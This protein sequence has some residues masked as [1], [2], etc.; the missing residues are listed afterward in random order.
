MGRQ[1]TI[2]NVEEL[3][4][5]KILSDQDCR[6]ILTISI[7]GESIRAKYLKKCEVSLHERSDASIWLVES[8]FSDCQFLGESEIACS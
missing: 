3:K 6:K 8:V 2:Q 1:L 7:E 5:D 4:Q